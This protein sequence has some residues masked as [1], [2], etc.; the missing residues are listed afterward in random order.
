MTGQRRVVVT[1]AAGRIGTAIT[2]RLGGRWQ[3]AATDRPR[4]AASD[5]DVTDL[6]ACQA[7]FSGADA[8]VHLAAVPDPGAEWDELLPANVVGSYNAAAADH[9]TR[10]DR[11]SSRSL[12]VGAV[13]DD[14]D[15]RGEPV[16][17]FGAL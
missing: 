16:G 1:G 12:H 11:Q 15:S 5:L 8:V 9:Q 4:R 7:A 3:I 10:G 2:E 6:A 14:G 17:P 13:T